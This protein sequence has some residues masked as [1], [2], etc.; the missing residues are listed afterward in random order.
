MNLTI[1]CEKH[2]QNQR[3]LPVI[4]GVVG[5]PWTE[6]PKDVEKHRRVCVQ[7]LAASM[8]NPIRKCG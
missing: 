7:C 5:T 6:W 1:D 3:A 2:G 4:N 8:V